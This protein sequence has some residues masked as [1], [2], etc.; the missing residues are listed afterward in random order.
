M[1][2]YML[3]NI[4]RWLLG[5][6]N[7]WAPSVQKLSMQVHM[8]LCL[9]RHS[10]IEIKKTSRID[11]EDFSAPSPDSQSAWALGV[12]SY[13]FWM[14]TDDSDSIWKLLYNPACSSACCWNSCLPNSSIVPRKLLKPEFRVKLTEERE[15]SCGYVL[16]DTFNWKCF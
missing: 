15:V 2:L 3:I 11:D 6:S 16:P 13:L 1:E 5:A 9:C 4:N 10:V 12:I 7:S 14:I 8:V